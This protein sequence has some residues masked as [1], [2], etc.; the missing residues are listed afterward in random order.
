MVYKEKI[1][2][3]FS[4]ADSA[5]ILFFA[6]Y[7]QICHDVMENFVCRNDMKWSDWYQSPEYGVPFRHAEADF[8]RPLELGNEYEVSVVIDEIKESS[9]VI[10]F[11][12]L[13]GEE[14]CAR[15]TL[16]PTFVDIRTRKKI[17]VP[18]RIRQQLEKAKQGHS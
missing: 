9:V 3:K 17:P 4:Q 6:R 5:G 13:R 12:F 8:F 16:V 14:R 1:R 18:D 2:I 10:G 7:F 11:D 15:I